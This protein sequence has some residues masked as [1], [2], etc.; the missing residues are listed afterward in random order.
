MSKAEM[1]KKNIDQQ[2][3][4]QEG[5]ELQEKP[6]G[7]ILNKILNVVLVITIIVAAVCTYVSFVSTSGNGVPSIFGIRILSIQTDSMYPTLLPGD[8]VFDVAVEDKS[9]LRQGDII[10]YW[11]VINGERVLNTHTILN[12][13]DGGGYLLFETKGDNNN[14]ADALTVHESEIVGKYVSRVPGVGKVMDYL[15]TSTGFLLVVV[16]PVFIFFLYHVIQFFRVLFE[17]QNV[18]NRLK[19]EMERGTTENLIEE[20]RRKE[21]EE[22]ERQRAAMEAEIRERLKA[23]LM[24]SM[25]KE[26][27][28][29]QAQPEPDPVVPAQQMPVTEAS[30]EVVAEATSAEEPIAEQ[31]PVEETP[32]QEKNTEEA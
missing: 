8:L 3:E 16:L 21:E 12:I 25:A 17:Y 23:E 4:G 28:A 13:Y 6:K 18:K 31:A 30:A 20:N 11:T 27:A 9:E 10:T 19:Y 14:I 7:A 15:Q 2:T 22:R 29:V 24:A 1:K 32:D 5:E 26:A